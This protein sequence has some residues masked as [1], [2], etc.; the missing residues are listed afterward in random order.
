M[1][2]TPDVRVETVSDEGF[3]AKAD[4]FLDAAEGS[5]PSKEAAGS[6]VAKGQDAGA[7]QFKNA[8]LDQKV[9]AETGV[10]AKL[11][12][13][14]E[15]LGDDTKAI[16]AYIQKQG[17]GKDPAWQK[18]LAKS[19]QASSIDGET[20][21]R[22]EEFNKVTSSPEYI[23]ASRKAQGYTDDAIDK[24][25]VEK[26]HQLPSKPTDDLNLIATT[27]GVDLSQMD[28]NTKAIVNDVARITDVI[29]KDRLGKILPSELG[30]IKDMAQNYEKEAG[31]D[32]V[33]REMIATTSREGILDFKVDVEPAINKFLEE[34][35]EATQQDIVRHFHTINHALTIERLKSGK[36][37]V[38]R[39]EKKATNRPNTNSMISGLKLPGKT[40]DF[41]KDADAILDALNVQ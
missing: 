6:E 4:A 26:G 39:T 10:E 41:V 17:Y 21:K 2:E 23:R 18:L 22:L 15:I 27:L 3:N 11:A 29:L 37:Q 5:S 33:L 25:L 20:Q 9:A 1:P 8:N 28:A 16:E 14:A 34:N 19:K 7:D 30:P 36:K 13:I 38:E 40:G 31:A 35:P 24:A 32:R 12:K